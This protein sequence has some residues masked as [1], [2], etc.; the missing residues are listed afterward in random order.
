V[1]NNNTVPAASAGGGDDDDGDDPKVN[2][3][4]SGDVDSDF[5]FDARLA[6]VQHQNDQNSDDIDKLSVDT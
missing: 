4:G 5:M 6:V 1:A 3:Y 2:I